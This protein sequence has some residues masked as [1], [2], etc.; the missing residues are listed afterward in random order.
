VT[1]FNLRANSVVREP[2]IQAFWEQQ[3]VY[4]RL[5]AENP[6]VSSSSS[7]SST[8]PHLA[9]DSTCS[10]LLPYFAMHRDGMQQ[11]V[12]PGKSSILRRAAAMVVGAFRFPLWNKLQQTTAFVS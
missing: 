5:A 8:P 3:Q 12:H 4:E 1:E 11:Q 7:S 10:R 6:G 9:Y 2:Q